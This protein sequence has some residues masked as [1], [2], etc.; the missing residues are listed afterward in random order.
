MNTFLRPILGSLALL[1]LCLSAPSGARAQ[2]DPALGSCLGFT[3]DPSKDFVQNFNNSCYGLTLQTGSGNHQAG[4][5]N[6]AYDQV[7]YQVTPGYSLVVLGPFP[8]ARFLS[9]TVYDD[10]LAVTSRLLD[11]QIMPLSTGMINPFEAGAVYQPGS[12]YGLTVSFGGQ[13]ASVAPGCSTSDTTID[14]NFLDASQIHQGLTWLGYPNLPANFPVHETGANAAGLITIRRYLDISNA[15]S[16]VVI[17]RQLSNGCAITAH[18]AVKQN[19]VSVNQKPSS[20]WLHQSQIKAHQ[21]FAEQIE[22]KLCYPSDPQN[23]ARFFRSQ[24]YI[25]IDNAGA[26]VDANVSAS[27]SELLSGNTYIR[28]RFVLPTVPTIPCT[29]GPCSLTGGEDLRYVSLAFQG[30]HDLYGDLTLGAIDDNSFVVDANRNV[31]LIVSLG[32]KQPST[33]TAANG[34]TYYDLSK[35]LNYPTLSRLEM[36]NLIPNAAFDCS[37]FSVPFFTMEYNPVG[38]FMGAY[39]PTVDFP[40][41]SE[42]PA[43]PVPPVRSDTC[44]AVPPPPVNCSTG[45]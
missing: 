44:L 33:A 7:Y 18:D 9:A 31:T 34:Y 13:V 5:P 3:I 10:H 2:V 12:T 22:P 39:V 40:T 43:T 26:N 45:S 15:Q 6:A 19:I 28:I 14:Q 21:Q 20:S 17:V 36:R 29:S 42:I 1:M 23:S 41:A 37:G 32:G 16:A 25:P 38:G 27:L 8:N 24:D 30:R 4:D 35:N 11:Y